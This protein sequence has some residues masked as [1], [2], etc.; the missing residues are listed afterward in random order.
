MCTANLSYQVLAF[1]KQKLF[2][3]GVRIHI[4]CD[5]IEQ[6]YCLSISIILIQLWKCFLILITQRVM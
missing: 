6:D 3:R 4:A 1:G 2:I 5:S